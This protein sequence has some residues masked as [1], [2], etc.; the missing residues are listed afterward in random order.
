MPDSVDVLRR[1]LANVE[2]QIEALS[3]VPPVAY[4][5]DGES[6]D[7]SRTMDRL[8]AQQVALRAAVIAAEGPS[9]VRVTGTT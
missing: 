8:L 1:A 5:L 9:E 7:T 2:A 4:G 3:T 6:V